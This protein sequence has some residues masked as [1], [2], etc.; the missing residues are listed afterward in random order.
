MTTTKIRSAMAPLVAAVAILSVLAVQAA[1]HDVTTVTF[2]NLSYQVMAPVLVVVHGPSAGGGVGTLDSGSPIRDQGGIVRPPAP[3]YAADVVFT[4]GMPASEALATLAET[5]SPAMLE[6]MLGRDLRV[7]S[8]A[9]LTGAATVIQPGESV[10]AEIETTPGQMV[11]LVGMLV[12]TNDAFAGARN[13]HVPYYGSVEVMLNAYD[14]GSEANTEMCSDIPG[15]PCA[16]DSGNMRVT[17]GAE[18]F[19]YVHPGIR[20]DAEITLD[21][22]WRN[23]VARVV[24]VGPRGN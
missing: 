20:G 21:R 1:A 15:P 2:T 18:G 24:V 19:V 9:V 22:D 5:G 14:A 10:A 7:S 8:T 13:I 11:T 12:S 16:E 17:A 4:P 23:P 6:T 3:G